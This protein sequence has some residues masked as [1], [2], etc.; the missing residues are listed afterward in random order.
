MGRPSLS[1]FVRFGIG[2]TIRIGREIQ[3]VPYAQFFSSHNILGFLSDETDGQCTICAKMLSKNGC[4]LPVTCHK[5]KP[6]YSS[7]SRL[8]CGCCQFLC[9]D[10]T[11]EAMFSVSV[12]FMAQLQLLSITGCQQR[13]NCICFQCQCT[14]MS[15]IKLP[16]ES[17]Y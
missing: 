6:W 4:C 11:E 15:G 8:D 17:W 1:I 13:L 16:S 12:Y 10:V 14:V 9:T 3:C 2:A 5:A 7:P